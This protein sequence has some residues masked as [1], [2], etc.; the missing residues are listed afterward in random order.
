MEKNPKWN[1][2]TGYHL[3]HRPDL[4]HL[5]FYRC[6]ECG[7]YVGCHKGSIRPLG[8][9]PSPE[10]KNA[11]KHIHALLDPLWRKR[12]GVKAGVGGIILLLVS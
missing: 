9:I 2:W 12:S 10:I 4:K 8:V 3:P 1:W 7:G 5:N 11:R 6:K